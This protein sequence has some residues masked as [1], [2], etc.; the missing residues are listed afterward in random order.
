MTALATAP[1]DLALLATPQAGS[2]SAQALTFD[3]AEDIWRG[4]ELDAAMTPYGRFEWAAAM[5]ATGRGTPWAVLFRD[6]AGRLL[7]ILPL[8]LE[9]RAGL[10]VASTLGGKHANYTLPLLRPGLLERLSSAEA[11]AM[12]VQAAGAVA[13]DAISLI[14]VPVEWEGRP[15]PF[16][17]LGRPAASTASSL[18]LAEDGEATLTRSMSG[19]ARKK[20]RSKLRSLQKIGSVELRQAANPGDVDQ[21]LRAFFDQKEARFRRLGIPDP[22]A[23]DEVRAALRAGALAGLDRKE[24]AIELYGLEVSGR[25]VAVLGGAADARRFSGMFLSFAE[26]PEA[27]FSPGEV[28]VTSVV[29]RLCEQGRAVFDL[30]VGEARYKSSIC[31][32][33]DQ[34]VDVDLPITWIGRAYVGARSA[35]QG[36]KLRLKASP[37][38]MAILGWS[39][40]KLAAI[41]A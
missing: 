8:A 27:R 16:A 19:D 40:R 2:A 17:A 39:R 34:L 31:D 29:R 25:I 28:L 38:A 12:L 20:L 21:I 6:G 23:T 30:G 7:A 13:A 9:R 3:A 14:H 36:S 37:R 5:A 26:G 22:F 18:R 10:T 24:P 1:A 41:R 11:R 35:A 4:F 32:T 15:N 33:V